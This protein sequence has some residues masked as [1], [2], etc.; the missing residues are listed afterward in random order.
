MLDIHKYI[1]VSDNRVDKEK[2]IV[3][4]IKEEI[5]EEGIDIKEEVVEEDPLFV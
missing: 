5:K 3:S 4:E 2:S 1:H